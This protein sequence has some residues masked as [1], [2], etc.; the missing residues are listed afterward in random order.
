ME[1]AKDQIVAAKYVPVFV[2]GNCDA[3]LVGGVTRESY[4]AH[5]CYLAPDGTWTSDAHEARQFD[6]DDDARREADRLP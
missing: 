1:I 4:P 2:S 6:S 5:G 3:H